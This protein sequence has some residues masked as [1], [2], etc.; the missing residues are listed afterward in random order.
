MGVSY[1]LNAWEMKLYHIRVVIDY[2]EQIL[3]ICI[4]LYFVPMKEYL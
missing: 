1:N 3:L 4:E 2:T